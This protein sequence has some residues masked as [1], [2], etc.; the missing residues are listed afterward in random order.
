MGHG[1]YKYY[2]SYVRRL[3]FED[4]EVYRLAQK[5]ANGVWRIIKQWDNFSKRQMGKQFTAY[6]R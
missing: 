6:F 1:N 4:L 3:D 5:W 2:F